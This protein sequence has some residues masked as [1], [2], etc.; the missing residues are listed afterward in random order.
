MKI[1]DVFIDLDN[2]L[3][4]FYA[5]EDAVLGK[6]LAACG[7]VPFAETLALYERINANLWHELEQGRVAVDDIG[8]RRFALLL[9]ALGE[10]GEPAQLAET[11]E[12]MLVDA[13]HFM[14]GAQALLETLSARYRLQ[15]VTNGMASVQYGRIQ[16]AGIGHYFDHLFVSSDLGAVKPHPEFFEACFAS[17]ADFDKSCAVIL[18]DGLGSDIRGGLAVGL[19]SIWYNPRHEENTT[20]WQPDAEVSDLAMVPSLLA[21]WERDA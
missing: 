17:I 20:P 2:T 18:G 13:C 5:S 21:E 8:V 7:I 19:R 16:A 14:P 4:D 3:L 6:A 1:K 9:E 12:A 11:Y 10:E 15:L